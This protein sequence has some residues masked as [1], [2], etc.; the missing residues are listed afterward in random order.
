[1]LSL[2]GRSSETFRSRLIGGQRRPREGD[3]AGRTLIHSFILV[4]LPFHLL[5]KLFI[6]ISMN[7]G[8]TTFRNHQA[9][10]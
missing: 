10:I 1:M 8:E 3:Y 6:D 7:A 9:Y 5:Y 2:S 4:Y